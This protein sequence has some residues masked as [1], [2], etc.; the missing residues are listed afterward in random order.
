[1][2]KITFLLFTFLIIS[3]DK[4]AYVSKIPLSNTKSHIEKINEIDSKELQ[5]K[6]HDE[7]IKLKDESKVDS[8]P[9]L[10]FYILMTGD[11]LDLETS[12]KKY[13][14]DPYLKYFR[15]YNLESI[16]TDLLQ[17]QIRNK[18]YRLFIEILNSY[19]HHELTLQ[20]FIPIAMELYEYNIKSVY[21]IESWYSDENEVKLLRKEQEE[22][23]V[24]SLEEYIKLNQAELLELLPYNNY[25]IARNLRRILDKYDEKTLTM[26]DGTDSVYRRSI[27]NNYDFMGDN[28]R[29]PK[30]MHTK[31]NE[32]LLTARQFLNWDNQ[33]AIRAEV[34]KGLYAN[35]INYGL[36]KSEFRRSGYFRT[37][38]IG[39]A[40]GFDFTNDTIDVT[41]TY[42]R[43]F[44]KE[45]GVITALKIA[46]NCGFSDCSEYSD[47]T[48]RGNWIN[49]DETAGSG[50]LY[51]NLIK[52]NQLKI[53]IIGQGSSG[54]I[55]TKYFNL[56]N[57]ENADVAY[58]ILQTMKDFMK[59]KNTRIE[60]IVKEK[61]FAE[62]WLDISSWI[63]QYREETNP[64]IY[65]FDKACDNFINDC[66]PCTFYNDYCKKY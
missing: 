25:Q 32:D 49:K 18:K 64:P 38:Y 40:A 27:I 57:S 1:M 30:S 26:L 2:K 47:I 4:S 66:D 46:T 28:H 17:Y 52:P 10:D 16:E 21:E 65:N 56:L 22:A 34:T 55:Y 48:I 58:N 15:T 54:W 44:Y 20:A 62:T 59:Y 41:Y 8:R 31:F 60:G 37:G 12:L 33:N 36:T 11:K 7:Y 42:N 53:D 3:C 50:D 45:S 14:D 19:P 35:L 13:P 29:L 5:E 9:L 63:N 6:I 61:S 43:K 24:Y 23:N 51:I 39:G